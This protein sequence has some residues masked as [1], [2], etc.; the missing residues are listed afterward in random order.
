MGNSVDHRET[1]PIPESWCPH[2]HAS[3]SPRKRSWRD[4]F[5]NLFYWTLVVINI[6]VLVLGAMERNDPHPPCEED[7]YCWSDPRMPKIE[8]VTLE[9]PETPKEVL[10]RDF[11]NLPPLPIRGGWGYDME[12]ACIIETSDDPDFP[13]DGVDVEYA[14]AAHRLYLELMFMRPLDDDG[15]EDIKF[16]RTRQTTRREGDRYFDV[17]TFQVSARAPEWADPFSPSTSSGKRRP[18]PLHT[19]EREFWFDITSFYGKYVFD[20]D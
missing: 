15:Y 3:T 18:A 11:P 20:E 10:K 17:L 8:F 7:P 14:F 13:L 2:C 6:V 9:T 12:T 4:V 19:G 16:T 5:H 1:E